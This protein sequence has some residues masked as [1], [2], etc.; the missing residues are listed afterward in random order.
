[1]AGLLYKD[2]IAIN[3]LK[4]VRLTWLLFGGTILYIAL[5][6]IFPGT[7]ELEDFMVISEKG[8]TFNLFDLIFILFFAVLLIIQISLI[9]GFIGKITDNDDKNKIKC[10]LAAMPIDKKTYISSKYIFVGIM[11]YAFMAFAYIW[12]ASC[13]AF[14]GNSGIIK[15][16]AAMLIKMV[17]LLYSLSLIIAAI[18]LMLFIL[19][20]KEKAM[21]AKILFLTIIAFTVIGYLMFGDL[22]GFKN[23]D[24]FVIVSYMKKFA[25]R[26]AIIRVCVM[27]FSLVFYY[28]SYRIT[29]Y[30]YEKREL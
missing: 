20:G 3:R 18:E 23:V 29:C 19:F 14:C 22:S 13:K 28:L 26:F 10:Y 25:S 1:M 17:I 24:I 8:E 27:I 5:R 6:M 15:D 7:R 4:R 11:T 21:M 30:C 16:L 2:F 9:N 12:G